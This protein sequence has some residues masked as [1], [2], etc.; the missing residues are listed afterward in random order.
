MSV[1]SLSIRTMLTI[2]TSMAH[3]FL[4]A[5]K[6]R[7]KI[8]HDSTTKGDFSI[9]EVYLQYLTREIGQLVKELAPYGIG[10]FV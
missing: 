7:Y 3:N 2:Q 9:D 10:I 8:P 5:T 4:I 1:S 6:D